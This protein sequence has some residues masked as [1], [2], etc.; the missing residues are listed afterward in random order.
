MAN[1]SNDTQRLEDLKRESEKIKKEIMVQRQF[2][3]CDNVCYFWQP[4]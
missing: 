4:T 3:F 1:Q 2:Y